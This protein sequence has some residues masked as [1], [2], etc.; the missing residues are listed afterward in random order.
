M[1]RDPFVI[2]PAPRR[3]GDE[4]RIYT[5]I[6]AGTS[7]TVTETADGSN[8]VALVTV[9][10]SGQQVTIGAAEA[11]V[12]ELT[13]T[14]TFAPGQVVVGKRISGPAAGQQGR[15]VLSPVCDGVALPP[16]VIPA[17][18]PA[19][20]VTHTYTGLPAG[21]LCTATE[22]PNGSR[23]QIVPVIHVA[24]PLPKRVPPGASARA[25]VNDAF[26]EASTA[27]TVHKTIKGPQ[28]GQQ[29]E[30][31]ITTKCGDTTLP[32][33]VIPAGSPAGTTSRTYKNLTPGTSCTV[34]E[35]SDG[36]TSQVGVQTTG[37]GQTVVVPVTGTQ[38]AFLTDTVAQGTSPSTTTGPTLP[39]TGA[40]AS[41]TWLLPLGLGFLL[42]GCLLL[43]ASGRPRPQEG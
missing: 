24:G 21:A 1:T 14:Y 7:C 27:I 30:I 6:P 35:T 22:T 23:G 42:S 3:S 28:A 26:A 32:P 11:A 40:P 41:A 16:F 18:T 19:G 37:D 34:H 4:F 20:L 13:D 43:L 31:V 2:P 17:G 5:D 8:S 38:D 36:H 10:G 25:V 12:A 39:N 33:L 29:G 15:I 9:T